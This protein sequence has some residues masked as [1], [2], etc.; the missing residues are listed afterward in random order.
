MVA[1]ETVGRCGPLEVSP[2]PAKAWDGPERSVLGC[3]DGW[4]QVAGV[5]RGPG[6]IQERDAVLLPP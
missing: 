2:E 1:E 5:P 4:L 3:R 6:G